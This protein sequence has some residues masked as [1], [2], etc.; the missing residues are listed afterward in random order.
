MRFSNESR[1]NS[2]QG[3]DAIF[4]YATEGILVTNEKSEI[5][6][7]NPSVNKLFGYESGEL[8]GQKI[9]VLIPKRY[10]EKHVVSRNEYHKNPHSRS[11]GSGLDL[12]GISKTGVEFPIEISLSSYTTNEGRFVVAFVL[13]ITL[14]KLAEDKLKNYSAD[15]EKQVGNRT[16][17]LEEAISELEKTKN[18]LHVALEKEKELN[19][20]KSRFVSMASHEFRTPLATIIS[21]LSLVKTYG[22]KNDSEKQNK[23]IGKIKS[24]INN[25]TD[26]LNDFL[27][28]SKMEEGKVHNVKEDFLIDFFVKEVVS[29]TESL[30]KKGQKISYS[31]SGDTI[32]SLDKKMFKNILFNLIS[33]AAK[34]SFADSVISIKTERTQDD[35]KLSIEDQGIGISKKEQKYL[36]QR[37][38]RAKNAS[39][40]Q[41]TGLGLNIIENYVELM[42]GTINFTSVENKG[43]IF[44][45]QFPQ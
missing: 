1:M 5:V 10:T 19:E 8:A 11:M 43:T 17:I 6:L 44:E 4:Y 21:S 45:L 23:H 28:I 33:N 35:L 38:F 7:S 15:L 39:N 34:F 25:L 2:E 20:M 31:H 27:S 37:F 32:V 18:E 3:F 26:I 30:C 14:R 9:E 16:L 40:I 29:E 36:F 41:G 42:D 12:F 13:D 22:D 24:S